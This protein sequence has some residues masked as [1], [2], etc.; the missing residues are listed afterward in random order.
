M[1]RF[2]GAGVLSMAFSLSLFAQ[3]LGTISGTVLDPSGALIPG[4]KITVT[5]A[6]TGLSRTATSDEQGRYVIPSLRPATYALTGENPGFSKFT[7]PGIALLADQSLTVNVTL[8][9]GAVAEEVTVEAAP[10]A[11]N[12]TTAT[13]GQVIELG[14]VDALPMNG[15]NAAALTLLVPGTVATPDAGA[16]Q[17]TTKTIPGALTISANGSR[18]NQISYM[19]DGGNNLD[20]YT[21]VNQPFPFPDALQEFSVQTSNFSAEYGQNAGGVVNIVTKS[22]S[23]S[24]HGDLFEYNRNA[25]YNARNFFST[26]R[27]PLKR[28]QYGG[29]IGG[30]II[31]DRTFFFAAYQGT[32]LRNIGNTTSATVPTQADI[33]AAGAAIDPAVRSMLKFLPQTSDPKG[34]VFFSRPDRQN[35]DEILGRVD[36][37]IGKADRLT[38]RYYY[39]RFH[40]DPVFNPANILT[41]AD[42]STIPFQNF[43]VHENH[44]FS[45]TFIND[46]HVNYARE[47]AR[48]GPADGVPNVRDFGVNIPFQPARK[49]IQ[50]VNVSGGFRFGDNP[51]ASFI[52]NNFT[53]SDDISWV[54]RQHDLRFGGTI[55]RSYVDI[56]NLFQQPG[57]FQ[58]NSISNFLLGRL[59]GNPGFR[60]GNG[61]FKNNRNTFAGLYI[62]D[63]YH[64]SRRL[65]LNAGLRWEPALPWREIKGRVEQFRLNDF[66]AGKKSIV[67]ANAPFGLFF[68]GDPGVPPNGTTGSLNLFSP[69][70]GFAYDVFGN[71]KSSIRGGVGI[72]YDSRTVG[73]INNRFVDVTPFSTQLTLSSPPGPFSDPLCQTT[74]SCQA[75]KITNPFPA[76]FP[77]SSN[78][79]FPSP[80]LAVTYD[81]SRKYLAPAIYN[82]NLTVEREVYAGWLV[83]LA[84]VGSHSSHLKEA[85]ELNPAPA[86]SIVAAGPSNVDD[87]RRLNNVFSASVF[88]VKLGNV[89]LDA[90]DINSSY[91]SMQVSLERRLARGVTILGNYTWSK[92]IDDLPYTGSGAGVS[93]LGGDAVSARPW[94]DPLRHRFDRGPS[95]FDHT[96]RFVLSFVAQ[97]PQFANANP[98]AR[99][100]LGRWSLSGIVAAQT[101]RPMTP[102]SGLTAGADM[103]QAGIGRDRAFIA[104]GNPYGSGACGTSAPCVDYL[105]VSLF[106]QPTVGTFGNAGKGS[107]RWPGYYN[108]DMGFSKEFK[109]TERYGVQFRTEF[110]NIFNRVNFRD[111]NNGSGFNNTVENVVNLNSRTFGTLRSALDPRIGQMAL[112]ILF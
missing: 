110:F 100:I 70:A 52:R 15:R 107:L 90:H 29:T 30:P 16:D 106:S 78:V 44:V 109:L 38:G 92:S 22:G 72:F 4:A 103:S 58:F 71:G 105:N 13:L 21:N 88:P 91:N 101:G 31:K 42:G 61:E 64:L 33:N 95:D 47:A 68:P 5:E 69:R 9:V 73:I 80:T 25:A 54:R 7:Q 66:Y 1:N 24:V 12:T 36:H 3:G 34:V 93:D 89:S 48:R 32:R 51:D 49:A 53:A 74:P 108:W 62:Q 50:L 40:K 111:T 87:R 96:H 43:L 18:Q 67:F 14:R 45:P 94:D 76:A 85:V 19:L 26:A 37:S 17:G 23:N 98:I 2:F 83:R 77:P 97:L 102:M 59:S 104:P 6:G 27:D 60:Q 65:T 28:N 11:V 75:Q 63:N 86:G 84:Y 20:E 46:V 8:R 56:D 82:W 81:P 112:K 10:P 79:A 57:E 35:F 39:V 41:Y 55:E 99:G